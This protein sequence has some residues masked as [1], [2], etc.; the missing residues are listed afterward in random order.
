MKIKINEKMISIPPY[1]STNWEQ[2]SFL[3]TEESPVGLLLIFHLKDG[4]SIKVPHLDPALIEIAFISHMKFLENATGRADVQ[5]QKPGGMIQ[6]LLGI[7]PDQIAAI[8]IRL[9]ISLPGNIENLETVF[10][11]NSAQANAPELPPEVIEKITSIT[12]MMTNGDVN[13][14]PKPEPHCNCMHCQVARGIHGGAASEEVAESVSD[15]DLKF[16][17]WEDRSLAIWGEKDRQFHLFYLP[18]PIYQR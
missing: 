14:F 11:H 6:S 12:R 3:H 2:V 16:K 17:N 4:M 8:P 7:S 1:I 15:E 9:G 13:N 5:A 18:H 10:Q